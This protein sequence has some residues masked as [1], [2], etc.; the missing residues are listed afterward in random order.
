MDCDVD[1]ILCLETQLTELETLECILAEDELEISDRKTTLEIKELCEKFHCCQTNKNDCSAILKNIVCLKCISFDVNLALSY[2][3]KNSQNLSA[4][5][6]INFLLPHGY[7]KETP[8]VFAHSGQWSREQQSLFNSRLTEYIDKN[9]AEEQI[10]YQII[11]WIKDSSE[12][13]FMG[14]IKEQKADIGNL[15]NS[16]I[17]SSKDA[18]AGKDSLFASMWLYM[19]HI[20][21]KEKRKDII[22]WS[23]ELELTGFSL[24]GKPGVVFVEGTKENVDDYFTRLRRLTWKRM[25]CVQKDTVVTLCRKFNDFQELSFD[26]HGSR[27]YHMDM[28]KFHCFLKENNLGSMF[29]VLFGIKDEG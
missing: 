18:A 23:K 1:F 16:E 2:E 4:T 6:S 9:M 17:R 24:P 15:N 7:P 22:N 26:A 5:L 25:S 20:Y 3:L 21:N 11:D 10:I 12:E 8:K 29:A 28:G 19:H 14:S 13:H 27:D